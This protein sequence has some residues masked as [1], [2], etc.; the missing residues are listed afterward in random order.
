MNGSVIQAVVHGHIPRRLPGNGKRRGKSRVRIVFRSKYCPCHGLV[1]RKQQKAVAFIGT[2]NPSVY[3]IPD[4]IAF[5][6]H[7]RRSD[8]I[9]SRNETIQIHGIFPCNI[10]IRKRLP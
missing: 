3:R 5:P 2:V 10:P 8:G 1:G 7:S 9:L 4:V 6:S